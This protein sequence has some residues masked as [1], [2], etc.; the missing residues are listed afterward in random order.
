MVKRHK[1][2]S[3]YTTED[4]LRNSWPLGGRGRSVADYVTV[5]VD[6]LN[7]RTALVPNNGPGPHRWSLGEIEPRGSQHA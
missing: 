7:N 6:G 4:N 5:Q 2:Y 1:G 3:E